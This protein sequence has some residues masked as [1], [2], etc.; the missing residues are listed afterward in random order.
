M[1]KAFILFAAFLL[2]SAVSYAQTEKGNQ[3]LGL[4]LGFNYNKTTGVSINTFDNSSVDAGSK[5]TSFN[6]GPSYSYFIADKLDLGAAVSYGQ[7]NSTYPDIP[8]NLSKTSSYAF[9]SSVY[10]RK[11]MMFM[12]KLGLRAGPYLGYER[13][14]NKY[15]YSGTDIFN[16]ENSKQDEYDAGAKLDLVYYPSK[17]L[18]FAASI[19]SVNYSHVKFDNGNSGHTSSDNVGVGFINN[20]LA[21]SVFYVLDSK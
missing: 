21:F 8:N 15:S 12:D 1:R 10:L 16:N 13:G 7:S 18:G 4:N 3:T 6:I 9:I 19:A 14:D 5:T 17:K 2:A 11:Y 20:N